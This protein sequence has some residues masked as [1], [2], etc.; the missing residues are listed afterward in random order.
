[1]RKRTLLPA[2]TPTTALL[3]A[4]V[5]GRT[6]NYTDSPQNLPAGHDSAVGDI[7]GDGYADLATGA[8]QESVGAATTTGAVTVLYGSASGLTTTGVS[9]TGTPGYGTALNG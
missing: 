4:L 7:N 3:T 5:D 6:G 9:T 1:L 2:A 8:S